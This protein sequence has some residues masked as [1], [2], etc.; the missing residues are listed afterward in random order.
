MNYKEVETGGKKYPLHFGMASLMRFCEEEQIELHEIHKAK[1][2]ATLRLFY[3]GIENGHRRAGI[4]LELS[5]QDFEDLIDDDAEFF[6][7]LSDVF[8]ASMPQE[9]P[10]PGKPG[11]KKGR[12]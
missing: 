3:K 6:A 10:E 4:P 8:A 12:P 11:K 9:E 2:T 5:Q 1:P 7:A